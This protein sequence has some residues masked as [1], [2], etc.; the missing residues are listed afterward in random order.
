VKILNKRI[1]ITLHF[2]KKPKKILIG[3]KCNL[4]AII[5]NKTDQRQFYLEA[6][7]IHKEILHCNL[8]IIFHK[9]LIQ[10]KLA[11]PSFKGNLLKLISTKAFLLLIIQ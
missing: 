3:K 1:S 5:I 2:L 9:T 6:M 10:L 4:E 7:R 11:I 8:L